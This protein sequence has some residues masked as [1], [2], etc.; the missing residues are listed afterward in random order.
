M[1]QPRRG[2]RRLPL[3]GGADPEVGSSPAAVAG[4][5][6]LTFATGYVQDVVRE[7]LPP[8]WLAGGRVFAVG[9][10]SMIEALRARAPELGL[11]GGGLHTNY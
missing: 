7:R 10:S 6:D 3:A 5:D 4:P 9:S 11:D 8:G 2:R 1:A